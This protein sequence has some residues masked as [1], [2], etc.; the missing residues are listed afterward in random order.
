MIP[1]KPNRL[2]AVPRTLEVRLEIMKA[3]RTL[4]AQDDGGLIRQRGADI[5]GLRSYVQKFDPNEPRVPAGTSDGGQWTSEGDDRNTNTTNSTVVMAARSRQSE[6]ECNAQLAADGII[7]NALHSR[8][9]W[10]QAM[11]RYSACLRGREIPPL[12]F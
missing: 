6:A 1:Y 10:A 11:E 12:S 8:A 4:T 5:A 7:C 2:I 9:C 3:I